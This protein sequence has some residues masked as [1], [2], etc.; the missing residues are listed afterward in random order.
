MSYNPGDFGGSGESGTVTVIPVKAVL[1]AN[2]L[3]G[4]VPL[5]ID[6]TT[7]GE[8]EDTDP[9]SPTYGQMIPVSSVGMEMILTIGYGN[10]SERTNG[11]TG[12]WTYT[13]REEGEFPVMLTAVGGTS[14]DVA[15]LMINALPPLPEQSANLI[16]RAMSIMARHPVEGNQQFGEDTRGDQV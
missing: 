10:T 7:Y 9:G 16:I 11:N 15:D 12:K 1:F 6:F 14:I 5:T 3:K 13:F 8:E 4:H 2:K